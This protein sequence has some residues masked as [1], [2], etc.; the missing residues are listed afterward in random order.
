MEQTQLQEEKKE[1][2]REDYIEIGREID[3]IAITKRRWEAVKEK[4][5]LSEGWKY[6]I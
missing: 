2:S 5:G 1:L 4:F 6:E 3:N